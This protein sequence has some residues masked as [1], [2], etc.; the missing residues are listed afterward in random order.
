M[1]EEVKVAVEGRSSSRSS[2][3][4][5]SSSRSSRTRLCV[6]DTCSYLLSHLILFVLDSLHRNC[7]HFGSSLDHAYVQLDPLTQCPRFKF[8][9]SRCADNAN[10]S[11]GQY[12]LLLLGN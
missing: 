12:N 8:T 9:I 5:S 4:N 3:R 2:S 11:H 10:A 1:V 6:R 7:K